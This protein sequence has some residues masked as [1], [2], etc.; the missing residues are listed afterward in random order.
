MKL[1]DKEKGQGALWKDFNWAKSLEAG[2]DYIDLP[3]SGEYGFIE[4]EMTLPLSHMVSPASKTVSCTECHSRNDSRI[5]NLTDF[6]MPGRDYNA[7]IDNGGVLL[8]I[9]SLLG[10]AAHSTIRIVS[11][12]KRKNSLESQNNEE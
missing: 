9:L 11:W 5:A 10:V 6:Y 2:M 8:I 4:T 12:R 7:A 1:W 3:Y